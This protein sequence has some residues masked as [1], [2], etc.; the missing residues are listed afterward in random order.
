MFHLCSA[1]VHEKVLFDKPV[2][3]KTQFLSPGLS[4]RREDGLAPRQVNQRL[5]EATATVRMIEL[6]ERELEGLKKI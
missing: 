5:F 4:G 2:R 6:D 1:V 3:M